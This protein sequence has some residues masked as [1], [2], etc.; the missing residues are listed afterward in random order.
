MGERQVRTKQSTGVCDGC[1]VFVRL[2]SSAD[3]ADDSSLITRAMV[4]GRR[5]YVGA[6]ID[7]GTQKNSI[8]QRSSSEVL[9]TDHPA[10]RGP[11]AFTDT[12]LID[13]IVSKDSVVAQ[14]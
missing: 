3:Y 6:K 7:C 10:V 9:Q 14:G 1:W 12:N 11:L 4:N 8:E 13:Q 2:S 5:F